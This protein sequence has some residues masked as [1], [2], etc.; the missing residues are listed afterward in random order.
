MFKNNFI[1]FTKSVSSNFYFLTTLSLKFQ[2]NLFSLSV[3][4]FKMCT[5]L[6]SNKTRSELDIEIKTPVCKVEKQ[7][8]NW[9]YESGIEV[10]LGRSRNHGFLPGDE[11][12]SRRNTQPVGGQV[13]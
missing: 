7:E 6:Q 8:E 4:D 9:E 11:G 3:N 1:V 12:L 5:R 13:D 10:N 2:H